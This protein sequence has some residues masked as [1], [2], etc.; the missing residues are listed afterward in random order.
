M[1][2][3]LSIVI[4]LFHPSDGQM[5][6]IK[7]LAHHYRVI[8][9]DNTPDNTS[10]SSYFS[11][12]PN[13]TYI[14]LGENLGIACAQNIGIRRAC[15][16]G[17]AYVVFFDQD[18]DVCPKLVGSLLDSYLR[19]ASTGEKVAAIGPLIINKDTGQPYK[20]RADLRE[21]YSETG[22]VISSGSIVAMDTFAAIGLMMEGLFIDYVDSEWC[23][24]AR[25]RGYKSFI[26]TTLHMPHKVGE[27]ERKV[28]GFP[29]LCAKPFRYYYVY[30]NI[31][32][33]YRK[34]H[35]PWVWKAK[36]FVRY[37]FCLFYLPITARG[38]GWEIFGFMLKGICDGA[39]GRTG[40]CPERKSS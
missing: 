21:R 35:V 2:N 4:V 6:H 29:V 26:D 20:H 15:E 24:R 3:L 11:D 39:R 22:F 23:W 1:E 8:A 16:G 7:E 13:V 17:A 33:L 36:S 19:L 32:L 38:N 27:N 18:S 31:L 25:N 28:L 10:F 14:V 5:T 30:R 12:V 34:R 40:A 37:F 9:V